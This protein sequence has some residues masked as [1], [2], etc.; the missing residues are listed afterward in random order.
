MIGVFIRLGGEGRTVE[1]DETNLF[2]R[3]YHR[4]NV[5]A[6]ENIWVFGLIECE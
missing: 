4:G 5:L 6:S 1:I 3:K 2:T